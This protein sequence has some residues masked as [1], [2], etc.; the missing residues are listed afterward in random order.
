METSRSSITSLPLKA[1]VAC[2]GMLSKYQMTDGFDNYW[3]ELGE[4][5]TSCLDDWREVLDSPC[6]QWILENQEDYI[7]TIRQ[8]LEEPLKLDGVRR[9]SLRPQRYDD[10]MI[11]VKFFAA[12]FQESYDMAV[13][14][15]AGQIITFSE[16]KENRRGDILGLFPPMMFCQAANKQSRQYI[17]IDDAFM[18][19]GI[20]MDHPFIV[21]LLEN[22]VQLNK[23]YQRQFQQIIHC[24]CNDAA[25]FII[26]E[27][28][29]I[30]EQFLALPERH[31]VDVSA[32]PKLGK[33]DFWYFS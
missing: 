12:Y 9:F 18:R 28:N 11:L 25:E 23:Y 29:G 31:G 14:Y 21:W 33:E 10:Y 24:L 17:C 15:E 32:F 13:D 20:T 30:R 27:C 4:W 6:S 3:F 5:K 22:A 26:K 1:I 19:Q 16:K 8:E 2:V 7:T